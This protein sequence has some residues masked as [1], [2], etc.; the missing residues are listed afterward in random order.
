MLSFFSVLFFF[1]LCGVFSAM[2]AGSK[3]RSALGWF[4]A[5]V[6][7]GPF[8]L[9]VGLMPVLERKQITEGEAHSP[10]PPASP[11]P[12]IYPCPNCDQI[13]TERLLSCPYCHFMLTPGL[14]DQA[15][16]RYH[17]PPSLEDPPPLDIP[18]EQPA[19]AL[20][21]EEASSSPTGNT[22]PDRLAALESLKAQGLI[23]EAEYTEK[24]VAFLSDL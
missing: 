1:L 24:R 22:I 3:G 11:A 17:P 4:V 7:F 9:L 13:L 6:L 21:L 20:N 12:P 15:I 18:L 14:I 5:G 16:S 2:L 10:A 23:T 19:L 8:G